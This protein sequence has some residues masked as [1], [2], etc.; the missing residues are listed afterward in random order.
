MSYSFYHVRT[1]NFHLHVRSNITSG[2]HQLVQIIRISMITYILFV[3]S[4]WTWAGWQ[5]L[6]I[7]FT[8]T[9]SNFSVLQRLY[10]HPIKR[11]SPNIYAI[12]HY[13]SGHPHTHTHRHRKRYGRHAL[14][15]SHFIRFF[16]TLTLCT[17]YGPSLKYFTLE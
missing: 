3:I 2:K 12:K 11:S 16:L 5:V 10:V 1:K 17:F 6:L 15:R 7:Y 14:N 8:M 9:Y 4:G 13:I